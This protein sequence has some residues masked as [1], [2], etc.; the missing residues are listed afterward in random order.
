MHDTPPSKLRKRC[1]SPKVRE[2]ADGERL[3]E[4]D[5]VT[6]GLQLFIRRS[7]L[8][9]ATTPK[10]ADQKPLP[11]R[12]A[13]QPPQK[14]RRGIAGKLAKRFKARASKPRVEEPWKCVHFDDRPV[15]L[16]E[17]IHKEDVDEWQ[18]THP[19]TVQ[20]VDG[21]L[22]RQ[23]GAMGDMSMASLKGDVGWLV[24]Y[25][26]LAR[27]NGRVS[28]FVTLRWEEDKVAWVMEN[29]CVEPRGNGLGPA[30]LRDVHRW[31][32]GSFKAAKY[33]QLWVVV[34]ETNVSSV[35]LYQNVELPLGSGKRFQEVPYDEARRLEVGL[36]AGDQCFRLGKPKPA[37]KASQRPRRHT[38]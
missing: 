25:F 19:H 22:Q 5:V 16:H 15:Q 37:S 32:V 20:Q 8:T 10:E 21:L 34:N 18:R 35:R 3:V 30:L 11:S 14:K 7:P 38:K 29:H 12:F 26:F 27:C 23:F 17:P 9:F 4:D 6:A 33:H 36:R 2:G 13:A 1:I 31:L 28:G 24:D